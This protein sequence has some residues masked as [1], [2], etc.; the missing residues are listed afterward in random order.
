MGTG[1]TELFRNNGCGHEKLRVVQRKTITDRSYR[2]LSSA[3]NQE[4]YNIFNLISYLWFLPE[5]PLT[6]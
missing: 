3:T 5:N 1:K 4:Q 2:S 6:R